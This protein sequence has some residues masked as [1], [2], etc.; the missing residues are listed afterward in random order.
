MEFNGTNYFV[1]SGGTR[2][3]LAKT[4]TATA[5]LNFPSTDG[6]GGT[7]SLN[8]TVTGAAV[9]DVVAIGVPPSA[10]EAGGTYYA[11]VSAANTVT[12]VFTNSLV[13]FFGIGVPVDPGSGTF[14]VS[15]T[16]Y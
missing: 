13:T 9:G 8:V 1:T 10:V 16:K 15:V 5:T 3:T 7:E 14:R 2:Y 11:Y 6:A 4:L 12:I